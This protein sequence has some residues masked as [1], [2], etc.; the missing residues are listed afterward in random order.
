[1]HRYWTLVGSETFEG[2]EPHGYFRVEQG[3]IELKNVYLNKE[4]L[5][6]LS[7]SSGGKYFPWSDRNKIIE[8]L[9]ITKSKRFYSYTINFSHWPP[10]LVLIVLFL[11]A[12]GAIR[13]SRGLQ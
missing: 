2:K 10:L 4:I 7:E 6:G 5:V 3:M 12:E 13:R 11:T 1:M 8:D 9:S